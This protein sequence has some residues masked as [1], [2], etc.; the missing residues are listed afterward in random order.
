VTTRLL[1]VAFLC[2][3]AL[4]SCYGGPSATTSPGRPLL[5]ASFPEEVDAGA[6]ATA[7]LRVSNPGPGAIAKLHVS[8]TLAGDPELPTPLIAIGGGRGSPSV[9]ATRPTGEP[10]P[11]G[12]YTFGGLGV[13]DEVTLEFDVRAPEDT[14]RAASSVQV[15]A[16]EDPDRIAGA[17]LETTVHD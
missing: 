6:V 16:G 17:L 8:F 12:I 1:I 9:V 3:A 2:G 14:G 4:T 7:V 11:G 13:G 15:Y 5:S 10:Q